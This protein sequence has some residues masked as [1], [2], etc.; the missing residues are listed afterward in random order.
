ME[1]ARNMIINKEERIVHKHMHKTEN[2]AL[3]INV[4]EELEVDVKGCLITDVF[5]VIDAFEDFVS[6]AMKLK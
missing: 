4:L 6:K 3:M 1:N 2:L 5:E